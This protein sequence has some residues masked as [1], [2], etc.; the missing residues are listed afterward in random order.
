MKRSHA[1]PIQMMRDRVMSRSERRA[2]RE[3]RFAEKHARE[4][5]RIAARTVAESRKTNPRGL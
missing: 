2:L 1:Y 3:Q 4:A 5:E